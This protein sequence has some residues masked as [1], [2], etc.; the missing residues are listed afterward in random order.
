MRNTLKLKLSGFLSAITLLMTFTLASVVTLAMLP[1]VPRASAAVSRCGRTLLPGSEWLG[2]QGVNVNSNGPDQGGDVSCST[3]TSYVNGTSAGSEWQCAELVVRLYLTRGWIPS[4][5]FWQGNGGGTDSLYYHAPAN[6]IKQPQGSI[7]YL[8]PGDAVMFNTSSSAGHVAI[9]NTVSP[10]GSIQ[11]VN[12]NFGTAPNPQWYTT[13]T[14]IGGTLTVSG[15][16]VIGVVHA[17]M[18]SVG[19]AGAGEVA[20][21]ANDPNHDLIEYGS[22]G[23]VNTGQGIAPGTSP[24]ITTVSGGHEMAFQANDPNHDLIVYGSAGNIN[25]GQ[26]MA[27]GTSPS[28]TAASGGYEVAF[29]ANN[30]NLYTFSS[31]TG[32]ANTGQGMA[33]GTSPSITALPNGGY[34]EAFQANTGN[35]IVV[36]SAGNVNTGQGMAPGTSPSITA[37]SG[38]YEV[39]F[40]ANNGNLYTF[41]STTGA[42][43]TGQ[44][45]TAG[46]SPSIT[47]ASGGYEM[48]FQANDPNH[49]LIA[50]GTAAD[51]NTGQGIAP[52]T[53]P[54]ITAVSG[55]YEMAFQAN[56]PNHDLIMYGT[57]ADANTGQGMA[58]GT[59]PSIS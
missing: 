11:F 48:A 31:T 51:V 23:N 26:G 24:S 30:G 3:A 45:M 56:D 27:P 44:G 39:A 25:T 16:S 6:L 35:L 1:H 47:A 22:A 43:N 2:G 18:H 59:N 4:S 57:A 21:Q 8:A 13:G 54:S 29:Q 28:I 53:S 41:S 14:L 10:G 7:S 32:P 33:A 34:E 46:T 58:P 37:V 40:Q 42:A 49:D 5:Y 20:F 19:S 17:P 52:G 55:G 12:Q 9:V 50:F 15:M 38:G 36:G